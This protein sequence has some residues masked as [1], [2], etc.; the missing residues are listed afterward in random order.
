MSSSL[1]KFL[2]FA[3]ISGIG[4]IIDFTIYT[5]LVYAFDFNVSTANFISAFPAVTFVFFFSTKKNFQKSQSKIKIR[6]KYLIYVVYQIFLVSA[7]SLLAEALDSIPVESVI[8]ISLILQ[9]KKIIIKCIIT[10]ITLLCNFFV[11]KFI[12]E[13]L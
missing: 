5:T 9:Y 6:Y 8:S 3:G 13:K 2:K 11:M 10:G 7:V 1:K 4:W 12:I